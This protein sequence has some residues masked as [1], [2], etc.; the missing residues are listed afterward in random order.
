MLLLE[1]YNHHLHETPRYS[2]NNPV[3]RAAFAP[4]AAVNESPIAP[5]ILTSLGLN[6]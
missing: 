3:K 1:N 6:L 4:L 5:I 2:V